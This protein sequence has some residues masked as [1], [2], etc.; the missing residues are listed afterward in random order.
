[1]CSSK[2]KIAFVSLVTIHG[3]HGVFMV[4]MFMATVIFC[5]VAKC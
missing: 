4:T 1:M 2:P 3:L 5:T